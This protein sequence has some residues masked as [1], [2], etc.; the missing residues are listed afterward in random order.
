MLSGIGT[1]EA[2]PFTKHFF[3]S[4]PSF[5][6]KLENTSTLVHELVH[7]AMDVNDVDRI[8]GC[9]GAKKQMHTTAEYQSFYCKTHK[10]PRN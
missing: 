6:V 3:N 10:K 8:P 9:Y 4:P 5:F 1:K 2:M 7:H